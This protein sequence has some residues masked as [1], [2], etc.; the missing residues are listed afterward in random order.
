[1]PLQRPTRHWGPFPTLDLGWPMIK[2]THIIYLDSGVCLDPS[3]LQTQGRLRADPLGP[4]EI[5]SLSPC[6]GQKR[7]WFVIGAIEYLSSF[8]Q[9]CPDYKDPALEIVEVTLCWDM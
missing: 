2:A 4:Q 9:D 7:V 3:L 1:M 6:S 8:L 5:Q